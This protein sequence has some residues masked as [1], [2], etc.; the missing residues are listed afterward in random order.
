[1]KQGFSSFDVSCIVKE[2]RQTILGIRVENVYS[3]QEDDKTKQQ[4]TKKNCH[5]V[6]LNGK[7][8]KF[9]LIF[10]PG[11][12]VHLTNYSWNKTLMPLSF[13]IKMRR[14]LNNKIISDIFQPS[15]DR[16]IIFKLG[17][18]E[19]AYYLIVQLYSKG[20]AILTDAKYVVISSLRYLA[21]KIDEISPHFYKIGTTYV[22]PEKKDNLL[23]NMKKSVENAK[24]GSV[25]NKTLR[26]SYFYGSELLHHIM[27]LC[28]LSFNIKLEEFVQLE[29]M[30][31]KIHDT[32]ITFVD[33]F[34]NLNKFTESVITLEISSLSEIVGVSVHSDI[35]EQK[36]FTGFYP[37]KMLF[38]TKNEKYSSFNEAVDVYFS[39][40]SDQRLE[41]Q[42][43]K[44]VEKAQKRHRNVV[45]DHLNRTQHLISKSKTLESNARNMESNLTRISNAIDVLGKIKQNDCNWDLINERLQDMKL[46]GIKFH[47]VYGDVEVVQY[48]LGLNL[49]DNEFFLN[50]H[51]LESDKD[52]KVTVNLNLSPYANIQ[53]HYNNKKN[54]MIKYQKTVESSE[55]AIKST[56][57]KCNQLMREAN[58]MDR[59]KKSRKPFWFEKFL[60]FIS[61]DGFI[62]IGG[63]DAMQNEVLMSR[64]LNKSDIYVHANVHGGSS[65]IVKNPQNL[66]IPN[67]TLHEAGLMSV[68]NSS[69]WNEHILEQAWWVY[70]NQV[71][72]TAPT[73]EYLTKGSFAIKGDKHFMKID[74]LV[75]GFGIIFKVPPK[76]FTD[77]KNVDIDVIMKQQISQIL[78]NLITRIELDIELSELNFSSEILDVMVVNTEKP[79]EAD[80]PTLEI[81]QKVTYDEYKASITEETTKT[82][83]PVT[84]KRRQ[85]GKL[86]KIKKKYG[87]Q[88]PDDYEQCMK[89]L[90]SSHQKPEKIKKNSKSNE[91]TVKTKSMKNI[92][93]VKKIDLK[94]S[95]NFELLDFDTTNTECD[96]IKNFRFNTDDFLD[97]IP[98]FCIAVAAPYS[99]LSQ[100]S[101]KA[102]IVPG[103]V[104]RGKA[105]KSA[106]NKFICRKNNQYVSTLLKSLKN[107]DISRNM[108]TNVKLLF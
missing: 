13:A 33:D 36:K 50:I 91:K 62:V 85:K 89:I 35:L 106:L 107:I 29:N 4:C 74:R 15:G 48:I 45:K 71:T 99:A 27:L 98:E 105:A 83:K 10:E 18:E 42:F 64:Y 39:T 69:C 94:P 93:L 84:L 25:M 59:I 101:F 23:E 104:K 21:P 43:N 73:G 78:S 54:N 53:K 6:K 57:V 24:P 68:V 46:Y 19:Y 86:K 44:K 77:E 103:S 108:P 17:F 82:T 40:K 11:K 65:V 22:L 31:E 51:D 80:T 87:N 95:S 14:H 67:R 8:R 30:V 60:W 72:K 96:A 102:K 79:I 32:T 81:K 5:L 88:H 38:L 52:I 90:N 92:N 41:S 70:S 28:N 47:K 61:S 12:R 3:I 1:M 75:Y 55:K 16:V 20:N 97:N 37:F 2:L 26:N 49:R 66:E 58:Q 100:Y 63:R 7:G 34:L 76:I 9:W 56:Q